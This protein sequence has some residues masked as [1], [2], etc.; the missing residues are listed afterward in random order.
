MTITPVQDSDINDQ[1]KDDYYYCVVSGLC[2]GDTSTTEKIYVN[3]VPEILITN[4]S[5]TD[6]CESESASFRI[7]A[8]PSDL[9][10]PISYR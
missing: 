7:T 10:D 4:P 3:W 6:R 5:N 2:G 9:S 8:T 1:S